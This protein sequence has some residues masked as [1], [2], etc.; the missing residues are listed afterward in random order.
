MCVCF[1]GF[2]GLQPAA[3]STR[4]SGMDSQVLWQ[5]PFQGDLEKQICG[6]ERRQ[7]VHLGERGQFREYLQTFIKAIFLNITIIDKGN[8]AHMTDTRLSY[9]V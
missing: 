2:A 4:Q 8:A 6:A 5:R 1:E 7:A 9:S 3:C